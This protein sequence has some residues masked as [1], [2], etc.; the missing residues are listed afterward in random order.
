[1][2]ETSYSIFI[3]LLF[4][5]RSVD[6][7]AVVAVCIIIL[8]LGVFY[9]YYVKTIKF[10]KEQARQLRELNYILDSMKSNLKTMDEPLDKFKETDIYNV[11]VMKKESRINL[12][13][14]D[15]QKMYNEIDIYFKSFKTTLYRIYP[16][17][18]H[19]YRICIL[20]KLQF[21]VAAIATLLH[22]ER[23]SISMARKRLCKK[24]FKDEENAAKF[25][26][27]IASI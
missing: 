26:T 14:V 18:E 19:E 12:T 2:K 24:F 21:S 27:F 8:L 13:E 11:F 23:S 3:M 17:K 5:Y 25:D 15:W 1:M 4:S 9:L 6:I 16:L 22:R 10:Q 7:I 20:I